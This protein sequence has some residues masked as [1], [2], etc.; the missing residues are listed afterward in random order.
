MAVLGIDIGSSGCKVVLFDEHGGILRHAHRSYQVRRPAQGVAELNIKEA[1]TA[2]FSAIRSCVA[3]APEVQALAVVSFGECCVP[4]AAD[5][6]LA[7][8]YCVMPEDSRSA[9]A[10]DLLR[11]KFSAEL[12]QKRTGVLPE[13]FY[14]LPLLSQQFKDSPE[15]KEKCTFL[16]DWSDYIAYR[17]SGKAVFNTSQASRTLAYDVHTGNWIPEFI[18]A[19]GLD[20]EMF[21]VLASPGTVLGNVLPEM[22]EQLGLSSE[23][24]VVTGTHDQC[25]AALGS[26]AA[27][28]EDLTLG[29]GTYACALFCCPDGTPPPEAWGKPLNI[30]PHAVPGHY[31]SYMFHG[32]CGALL[33][34]VAENLFADFAGNKRF[35]RIFDAAKEFLPRQTPAVLPGFSAG[36]G[37][38][39]GISYGHDRMDILQAVCEGMLF[40]F[41]ESVK[42]M[43]L[44]QIFIT[45]GV[46][47]SP[48]ILQ[49]AADILELPVIRRDTPE[50]GALGCAL[51]AGNVCGFCQNAGSLSLQEIRFEPKHDFSE[52]YNRWLNDWK[53]I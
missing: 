27:T 5:G 53:R 38:I 31:A 50:A 39:G 22:A 14:T 36:N 47:R 41:R 49:L 46:G 10:A 51:L 4:V 11:E 28:P 30:E 1:E 13:S 3:D 35:E 34:W 44:K 26:G 24:V 32:S 33:E 52:S 43:P 40:Y 8:P 16:L 37:M 23:T 9:A 7:A 6:L 17:L 15:L 12:I 29:L 2:I 21:P 20:T 19:A 48:Q 45:G 18:T 25:A 42:A